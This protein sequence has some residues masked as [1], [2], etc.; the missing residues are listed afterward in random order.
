MVIYMPVHKHVH[1]RMNMHV[2]MH[3]H[4]ITCTC[5]CTC[6]P[7]RIRAHTTPHANAHTRTQ[8]MN[9]VAPTKI[10]ISNH[11]CTHGHQHMP[12]LSHC[13]EHNFLQEPEIKKEN[14]VQK[15][16][17]ETFNSKRMQAVQRLLHVHT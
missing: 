6:A 10:V 14:H 13:A 7:I 11:E 1:A 8:D 16:K 12:S 4:G 17:K 3:K 15:R 5:T 9:N 2:H